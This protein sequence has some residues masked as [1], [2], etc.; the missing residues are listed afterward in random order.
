MPAQPT[1]PTRATPEHRKQVRGLALVT[2]IVLLAHWGLL[3]G[4]PL[5]VAAFQ[6]RDA[7]PAALV[8]RPFITRTIQLEAPEVPQPVARL[9]KV[10]VMQPL[11]AATGE[12]GQ[13]AAPDQ[14]EQAQTAIDTIANPDPLPAPASGQDVQLAA[15]NTATAANARLPDAQALQNYAFPAS[16]RLNYD[17]KGE[18]K[19]FP[20][21]AN[22]E[23]LWLQDG[24][25][26]DAR[27]EI[28]H[29]LLGSR[30]QTSKGQLSPQGLAPVRFGDKVRSEV[31]AHF[32]RNMGKVVFSANTP[33]AP[34]LPG[35]QDHLSVFLQLA[36]ML[37]GDPNRFPAGTQIPF[38]AIGPRSSESWTFVMG[39]TEVQALPG[40]SITA[41]KLVRA[42]V[43]DHD[44]RVEVWLAPEMAY[45]PV[46]IRL[47]QGNGDFVEQQWSG[48][49]KP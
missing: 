38:Q 5:A 36:S 11:L 25:T 32:D 37:G 24:K 27:L 19:G 33:D 49:Q 41:I 17:V 14:A 28:S 48:T 46:R 22:G 31:A 12:P 18:V 10:Q 4:L 21:F 45:M 30:V 20:Y 34:L 44:P 29:F 15:A 2:A 7:T 39:E 16:V 23:L 35:A 9:P 3:H 47:T 8:D 40:G 13:D 26:Y 1:P 6:G 43:G 42:P